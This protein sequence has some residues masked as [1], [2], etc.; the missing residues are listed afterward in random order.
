MRNTLIVVVSFIA[1]AIYI[2]LMQS[3]GGGG[4][5]RSTHMTSLEQQSSGQQDNEP[6]A[7]DTENPPDNQPGN[8]DSQTGGDGGNEGPSGH[9]V[10]P[11]GE[12]ATIIKYYDGEEYPPPLEIRD[13][14]YY[15]VRYNWD[16][17]V[18]EGDFSL[19]PELNCGE[20]CVGEFQLEV[21]DNWKTY[22]G[23]QVV[24]I[25]IKANDVNNVGNLSLLLACNN[26]DYVP[27]W[28]EPGD[29]FP[30]EDY[31]TSLVGNDTIAADGGMWIRTSNYNNLYWV[32]YKPGNFAGLNGYECGWSGS[33]IVAYAYFLKESYYCPEQQ[34][35]RY[36]NIEGYREYAEVPPI[37]F[38]LSDIYTP[39]M[40]G[41]RQ[42]PRLDN[43]FAALDSGDLEGYYIQPSLTASKS[44]SR[45]EEDDYTWDELTPEDKV[46]DYPP[47]AATPACALTTD[48]FTLWPINSDWTVDEDSAD[49]YEVY[50]S[51]SAQ[52]D[53]EG[54]YD[55][56]LEINANDAPEWIG[57]WLVVNYPAD[58]E[59]DY[60]EVG[61]FFGDENERFGAA[62]TG[63]CE[64]M[65]AG[66][67]RMN[68]ETNGGCDGSGWIETLHFKYNPN[69]RGGGGDDLIGGNNGGD[70][71][72][73]TSIYRLTRRFA[74]QFNIPRDASQYFQ[75]TTMDSRYTEVY[76]AHY[77]F[78][79]VNGGD[80]NND[81]RIN[82][83]DIT[84]IARYYNQYLTVPNNY[85]QPI[86]YVD[87]DMSNRITI[88]DITP[89]S[90][91]YGF[92]NRGI[93][94]QLYQTLSGNQFY[95]D[96]TERV[97]LRS[98]PYIYYTGSDPLVHPMY[99]VLCGE[100]GSY[101]ARHSF[102]E[103]QNG[104]WDYAHRYLHHGEKYIYYVVSDD[105]QGYTFNWTIRNP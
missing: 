32:E 1:I 27:L 44:I 103:L 75:G 67:V 3:C 94:V 24:R 47:A 73:M 69:R 61:T 34:W 59:F 92:W 83:T 21:T 95:E 14:V 13:N 56:E 2:V 52:P 78:R 26:A 30:L 77:Q 80:Y 42:N 82:I 39:E 53:L 40:F 50:E 48:N 60:Q 23:L 57:S 58:F 35:T 16:K 87:G 22:A 101:I 15:Q 20:E 45:T 54:N 79:E 98:S 76:K 18:K 72:K 64:Y 84:P 7:S 97:F 55:V 100:N 88:G 104:N 85:E 31:H 102:N 6:P 36:T 86:T 10:D 28:V 12:N 38:V 46:E 74:A 29:I 4:S 17:E 33:G 41:G 9:E 5:S 25:A 105:Q 91:N 90:L 70:G 71:G 51:C 68:Y 19:I 49:Y 11:N 65:E 89:I 8:G 66:V 43:C 37:A 96:D 62:L 93:Y 99:D 63:I 81:T